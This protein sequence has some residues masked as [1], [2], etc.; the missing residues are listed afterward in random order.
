MEDVRLTATNPADSTI[1]PVACNDK[2]EILLE[3]PIQGPAGEQGPQ[4]EPGEQGPQGQQGEQGPQGEQGEQGPQ[5]E[6]GEQGPQGEP[7]LQGP[8][9]E[10][11]LPPDPY[12]GALLGWLNDGL[13]W[14]GTPP[15][16]LPEGIFGP[17]VSWDRSSSYLEV[18]G[19]IPDVASGVHIW[20]VDE[21][22]EYWNEDYNAS[23]DY[24]ALITT[25][26]CSTGV[27]N[28][29]ASVFDGRL[30]T[31]VRAAAQGTVGSLIIPSGT[32][33][34]DVRVHTDCAG[35]GG[36]FQYK[37][38]NTVNSITPNSRGWNS[39][40][41][42]DLTEL[43]F[44]WPSSGNIVFVNAI[45]L[46][47]KILRPFDQSLKMRVNQTIGSGFVGLPQPEDQNFTVGKYLKLPAQRVAPWVLYGNDPSLLIDHLRQSRD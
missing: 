38:G 32:I 28:D 9:G 1:V 31:G 29:L 24:L 26:N 44:G 19:E 20:Q 43:S 17:I 3:E 40:G 8:P 2:G 37:N 25:S 22:G 7:G 46:D 6:Q 42:I 15:V 41:N 45:E 11:E 14:V 13:A 33:T 47:G 27:G 35:G 36:S 4:G 12:E 16:E 21:S 39:L 34:G 5:G 18:Q 30:D 23:K 10:I